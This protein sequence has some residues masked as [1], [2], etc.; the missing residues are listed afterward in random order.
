M[1]TAP[2]GALS[3]ESTNNDLLLWFVV[4]LPWDNLLWTIQKVLYKFQGIKLYLGKV[5]CWK[6]NTEAIPLFKKNPSRLGLDSLWIFFSCKE[7]A[8]IENLGSRAYLDFSFMCQLY[9]HTNLLSDILSLPTWVYFSWPSPLLMPFHRANWKE[10]SFGEHVFCLILFLGGTFQSWNHTVFC[11]R[12]SYLRNI[13]LGWLQRASLWAK[14]WSKK[15]CVFFGTD[16]ETG[17]KL[18]KQ[19]PTRS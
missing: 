13:L 6:K 14:Y 18:S 12:M 7:H 8:I 3:A 19:L 16:G 10:I 2:L 1:L 5:C 11:C 9:L 17:V 15:P 4:R